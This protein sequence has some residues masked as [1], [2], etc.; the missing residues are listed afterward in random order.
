VLGADKGVGLEVK[1][2]K[3]KKYCDMT[4]ES[5]NNLTGQIVEILCCWAL[6]IALTLSKN[7]VCFSKHNVSETGFFLRL[8]VKPTQLDPIDRGNPYL[9]TNRPLLANSSPSAWLLQN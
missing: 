1:G 2:K 5:L 3:T 7:T 4:A 6:S 8:Q 9:R